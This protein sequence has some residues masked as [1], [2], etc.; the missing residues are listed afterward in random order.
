MEGAGAEDVVAAV[1]VLSL[2][3]WTASIS[4]GP[5]TLRAIELQISQVLRMRNSSK[6]IRA[7]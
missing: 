3:C 6:I 5:T 2:A 7:E 4:L 1:A